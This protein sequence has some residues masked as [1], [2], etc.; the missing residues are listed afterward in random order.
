MIYDRL[1]RLGAAV[2][3]STVGALLAL[4]A[5]AQEFTFRMTH[6][7]P[8]QAIGHRA[9]L[10]PWAERIE[11]ASDGRIK[12]EI[13]PALQL[14]GTASDIYSQVR[15][16]VV[17]L[18]WT[19][20]GYTAGLFPLTEMFELPFIAGSAEATSPALMEF[21]DEYLQD[22]WSDVKVL[23]LHT[24]APGNLYTVNTT[25]DE[26]A[27]IQGM[28]VRA[29]SSVGVETIE[30]WNA[31]PVGMPVPQVY[32]ALSRGVVEGTL[33]P[34]TIMGPTRIYEVT[35]HATEL[36]VLA[37]T[38]ALFM[39]KDAYESLPDDLKQIL[40][41]NT[42][43]EL[44]K[45]AGAIWDEDERAVRQRAI[46]AGVEVVTL[47]QAELEVWKETAQPV[48]DAWAKSVEAK[49]LPAREM[50]DRAR[51]LIDKHAA[52]ASQ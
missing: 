6:H 21:Y 28:K 47:D 31:V 50:L 44:A 4:P 36:G 32:E 22:E 46:D 5:V 14:G 41:E 1:K 19:L 30:A 39:N 38:F 16:G 34:W 11:E 18:G 37:S 2:A 20:P 42:D 40:A 29:P 7:L 23:L 26:L 52:E 25:V 27:D 45:R 10:Q 12:I 33:L 9:L 48:I 43:I 15:D 35:G 51:E 24:T 13:Y 3:L 17:D 8:P 49:G